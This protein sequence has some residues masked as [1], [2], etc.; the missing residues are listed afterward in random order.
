[1]RCFSSMLSVAGDCG[2]LS[3]GGRL[4][5]CSAL[6]LG[7]TPAQFTFV[8]TTLYVPCD[9]GLLATRDVSRL[10]PKASSSI[11]RDRRLCTADSTASAR[12]APLANQLV[13]N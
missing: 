5:R 10:P 12:Y 13:C 3:S 4:R 6:D 2:V 11:S 8:T 9:D 1:M 7:T